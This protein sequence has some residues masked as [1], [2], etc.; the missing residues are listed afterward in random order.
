MKRISFQGE[1]GAYSEIAAEKFFENNIDFYPSYSF[2]D[3]FKK[4]KQKKVDYG[5]VPIENS[6]YGSVFETYDLLLKY[7]L[8]IYGELN[9]KI[10]HALI[11]DKKHKISDL[12][13]IFSHP[14]ALGQCSDFLSKYKNLK[15]HPAYDTAGAVLLSEKVKEPSAAIASEKAAEIYGKKIIK[16]KIQNND[17]NY[18]RFLIIGRNKKIEEPINPKSSICFELKSIP[19]ALF[20]ALSVFALRDIDL[21]K[22]ESRPIPHKPFQYLFYVDLKGSLNEEVIKK[23]INNLSEITIRIIKFGTYSSGKTYSG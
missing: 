21:L 9:L 16:N 15:V 19:G 8:K 7:S 3:V 11:S 1:R 12:K 20:R 4:V 6:S 2:D 13:H 17:E 10:N 22:I 23:A 14:Q 5:I 18:T